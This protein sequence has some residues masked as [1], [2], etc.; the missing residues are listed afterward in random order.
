MKIHPDTPQIDVEA[1]PPSSY[2]SSTPDVNTA[3]TSLP[4]PDQTIE[5]FGNSFTVNPASDHT[6]TTK[7]KIIGVSLVVATAL[8]LC[9]NIYLFKIVAKKYKAGPFEMLFLRGFNAVVMSLIVIPIQKVPVFTH[10]RDEIILIASRTG[11]LVIN[12]TLYFVALLKISA[13]LVSVIYCALPVIVAV[14]ARIF[15]NERILLPDLGCIIL[16]VFGLAFITKQPAALFGKTDESSSWSYYINILFVL[17]AMTLYAILGLISRKMK[18][19]VN[20]FDVSLYY[21]IA[22]MFSQF[23]IIYFWNIDAVF[24]VEKFFAIMGMH[25]VVYVGF[26]TFHYAHKYLLAIDVSFY[27]FIQAI[28][29]V[30]IDYAILSVDMGVYDIVGSVILISA[31]ALL[32]VIKVV[33]E[34]RA[35]R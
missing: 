22:L 14:L 9:A 17:L 11:V 5:Q 21:G 16:G 19:K 23:L 30:I 4:N 24:E 35:S 13:S 27:I 33:R 20:Y 29:A 31:G 7:D 12:N 25:L 1:L 10:T 2:K 26:M 34:H 6:N 32:T 18:G 15:M 8:L 28:I 3:H